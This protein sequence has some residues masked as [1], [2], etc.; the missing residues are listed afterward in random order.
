MNWLA[1]CSIPQKLMWISLLTVLPALIFACAGFLGYEIASD[2]RQTIEEYRERARLL[3]RICSESLKNQDFSTATSLL[4][5][6]SANSRIAAACIYDENGRGFARYVRSDYLNYDFPRVQLEGAWI[7]KNQI[8]V[9]SRIT[10]AGEFI[11]TVYLLSDVEGV[12]VRVWKYMAVLIIVA[13][14][15]GGIALVLSYRFHSLITKPITLLA[16]TAKEIAEK[17]DY[18][19]RAKKLADDEI[20]KLVESFNWMLEQIQKREEELL[21]ASNELDKRV[22]ERT[23]ELEQANEKLKRENLERKNIEESL[24]NSQHKL[25]LHIQQTPLGVIDWTLD[26]RAINWNPAAER[27][28]GFKESEVIGKRA[29]DLIIPE[30][31]KLDNKKNWELLLKREGGTHIVTKNKTKS[32]KVITVEWFNTLLTNVDGTPVGVAS[33]VQDITREIEAELELRRSEEQLRRSQ[34]MQ[35]VGQLAAG[36]AHDFNNVLTVIQGH[37]GLLLSRENP[38]SHS[39]E[40]LK[41]V[42]DASAR[43]ANLVK[44]LLTFSRGSTVKTEL[45][46][47]NDVVAGFYQ[48][49]SKVLGEH[50]KTEINL[51]SSP[52]P[53]N[54]NSSLIEQMILNLSLNARDAMPDGGRL[55][56]KTQNV[57]I[58][59]ENVDQHPE[60]KEGIYACLIVSDTGCGMD[61]KTKQRI[62]EPFFTTKEQGKGTGLGLAVVYGIAKQHNGWI[63]VESEKG[64]GTTFK[65]YFPLLSETVLAKTKESLPQLTEEQLRGSENVLV[66]EDEPALRELVCGI[67][68]YYGYRAVPACSGVEA[69]K[70]WERYNHDFD[71]L[72]TD[73]IMPEGMT[74]REL[75]QKLKSDKPDLKVIYTSGYT[76]ESGFN[77][78]A[79]RDGYIF[80]S[81]P[82]HPVVMLK[83]VRLFLDN[84]Y[85]QLNQHSET[86]FKNQSIDRLI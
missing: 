30:E 74:G 49:I 19:A 23:R 24:R 7:K 3:G 50:I 9:F 17:E 79:I 61:E 36:V 27:I 65:I 48:L 54:G 21:K 20:G 32:G 85:L 39:Y 5:S 63:E 80:L 37:I 58:D 60:S 62:F 18:S 84:K 55:L 56:F 15:S 26:Q 35:A 16:S 40:S 76:I 86:Q 6:L 10:Y 59:R 11:G 1:R 73:M 83:T 66:V 29:E 28:F 42:Y 34:K 75:A 43:A 64:R 68:S 44:Q 77:D 52:L 46:D 38:D 53:I 13:I 71:L 82:Y 57:I 22:Q 25:M 14:I 33:L 47:L 78:F 12:G 4:S 41:L 72:L 8:E 67:L 2:R 69:L 45:L 70:V 31:L 81:K 51:E